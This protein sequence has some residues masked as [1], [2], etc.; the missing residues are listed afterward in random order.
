MTLQE[1]M[2]YWMPAKRV[3]GGFFTPQESVAKSRQLSALFGIEYPKAQHWTFIELTPE[4]KSQLVALVGPHGQTILKAMEIRNGT[5][6][7]ETQ[8]QV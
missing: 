3:F 5:K 8:V 6:A 4:L 7:E 1:A 2:K